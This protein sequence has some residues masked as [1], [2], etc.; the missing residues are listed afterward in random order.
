MLKSWI[1]EG[2]RAQAPKK[3]A[4]SY[5]GGAGSLRSKK[6]ARPQRDKRDG[7]RS[8]TRPCSVDRL[9]INVRSQRVR[10]PRFFLFAETA[11]FAPP[12]NVRSR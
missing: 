1:D 5:A 2:Y 4:A 8:L 7:G 6:T 3:L 12:G 9:V 11:E 10:H